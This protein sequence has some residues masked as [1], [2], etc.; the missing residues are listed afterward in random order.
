MPEQTKSKEQTNSPKKDASFEKGTLSSK[1]NFRF[2]KSV[3]TDP[4]EN[5]IYLN[6]VSHQSLPY[7]NRFAKEVGWGIATGFTGIPITYPL[8]YLESRLY[9]Q[10]IPLDIFPHW[11]HD[12]NLRFAVRFRDPIVEELIFRGVLLHGLHAG[13][14]KQLDMKDAEAATASSVINS[15]IFSALHARGRRL[16]TFV[17]G[18]IYSGMTYY[19]NGS[20]MPAISSHITNNIIATSL[21]NRSLRR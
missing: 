5:N 15:L 3:P 21:M 4:V 2:F 7:S 20:L 16:D 6:M 17:G 1:Q 9:R 19:C 11:Q 13:F 18:M 8:R 12:K 14:T 10:R